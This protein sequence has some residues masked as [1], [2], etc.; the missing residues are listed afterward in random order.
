MAFRSFIVECEKLCL[1][2]DKDIK[3]LKNEE[4][5]KCGIKLSLDYKP[6]IIKIM[7]IRKLKSLA[8]VVKIKKAIR[9]IRK[10]GVRVDFQEVAEMAGVTDPTVRKYFGDEIKVLRRLS[11]KPGAGTAINKI[12]R[13]QRSEESKNVLIETLKK[14]K[15]KLESENVELKK[16]NKVLLSKNIEIN[17]EVARLARIVEGNKK[18]D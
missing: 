7:A 4:I 15:A 6:N 8:D 9:Q 14:R 1:A 5:I 10:K 2:V 16:E 12:K 18:D 3:S 11:P 17:E 13:G